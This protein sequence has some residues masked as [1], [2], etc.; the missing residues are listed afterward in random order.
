MGKFGE[1]LAD[2]RDVQ[3]LG[4]GLAEGI[5]SHEAD[6]GATRGVCGIA[7]YKS[8]ICGLRWTGAADSTTDQAMEPHGSKHH[9]ARA[10]VPPRRADDEVVSHLSKRTH[11]WPVWFQR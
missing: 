9:P 3:G 2:R 6:G 4:P 11:L 1:G 8:S 7:A 5:V 10:V